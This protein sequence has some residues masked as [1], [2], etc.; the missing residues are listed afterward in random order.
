VQ[1]VQLDLLA[2]SVLLVLLALREHLEQTALF[3]AQLV[4]LDQLVL[5]D[6]KVLQVATVKTGQL[7]LLG[8]L[9]Q[10]VRLDQLD[11]LALKVPLVY[12]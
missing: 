9:E 6:H 8:P 10:L 1:Q 5:L 3:L 11:R 2:Q 7:E 12:R 4:R